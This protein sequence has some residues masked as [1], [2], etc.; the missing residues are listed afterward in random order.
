MVGSRIAAEAKEIGIEVIGK[1]SGQLDLR[2]RELVFSE[3]MR[4]R[5]DSVIIAAAKVGG[6][7]ANSKHPVAFLSENLQIQTNLLDAAHNADIKNLLFL[8]SSC[9]YP[10]LAPQPIS[11]DALLTGPLEETNE[12]Y[13]IAKIA[14][15]KLVQSYRKEYGR[16]WISAMPTNLYGPNDNFNLQHSHVLPSLLRKFHEAKISSSASVLIWGDGRPLREFLHVSDMARACLKLI[17]TPEAPEIVNIGSGEEVSITELA[18]LI[19]T[20]VGFQGKISYDL[21]QPNGTPRKLLDSRR[22]LSLG[23]KPKI[24]LVDGIISTYND[25]VKNQM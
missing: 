22:M 12:A 8:G 20:V 11:E 21:T 23:W 14:G 13:A 18:K 17:T 24:S 16:N 5:P 1:S 6:I 4:V 15:V 3:L 9:I 25:Y 7:G 19:A 2:N 10:R